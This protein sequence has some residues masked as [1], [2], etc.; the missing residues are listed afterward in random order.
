MEN[1]YDFIDNG[2]K[3]SVVTFAGKA[4]FSSHLTSLEEHLREAIADGAKLAYSFLGT[5]AETATSSGSSS[6]VR[7]IL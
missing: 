5:F 7:I 3:K 4:D 2:N 6:L 1:Y